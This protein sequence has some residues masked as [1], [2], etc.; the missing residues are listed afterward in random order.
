MKT[1]L[2]EI[3]AQG[4]FWVGIGSLPLAIVLFVMA[5]RGKVAW[6]AL[7]MFAIGSI[8]LTH[9]LWYFNYLGGALATKSGHFQPTSWW[10]FYLFGFIVAVILSGIYLC[11]RLV[12]VKLSEVPTVKCETKK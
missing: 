7:V 1:P 11:W 3:I 2:Q 12:S 4:M 10:H 5:F 6:K 8:A 9:F